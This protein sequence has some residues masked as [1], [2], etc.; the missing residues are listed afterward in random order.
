VVL[1]GCNEMKGSSRKGQDGKKIENQTQT[2]SV[3]QLLL[4][5]VPLLLER[6]PMLI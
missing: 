2:R 3:L 1:N 5:L 6:S 4:F